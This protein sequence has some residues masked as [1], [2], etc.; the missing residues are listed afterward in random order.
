MT[1][2]STTGDSGVLKEAVTPLF[3]GKQFWLS[4][5]IPQ[6]KWFKELIENLPSDTYSFKYVE[7]SHRLGKL[8][9]LENYRA[10]PSEARPVGATNIPTRG[11]K[12]PYTLEDDQLLWDWMQPHERNPKASIRGN[13]IYQ[14]LA[15]KHP[16]HTYQSYRDRYLKRLKG[17]PRPGGMPESTDQPAPDGPSNLATRL[18]QSEPRGGSAQ[19]V[20]PTAMQANDK[21]R[22]RASEDTPGEGNVDST[23]KPSLKKRVTEVNIDLPDPFISGPQTKLAAVPHSATASNGQR[24]T[25]GAKEARERGATEGSKAPA[26]EPRQPSQPDPLFLELPFLP[27]DDEPEEEDMEQDIDAWID[28]RLLNGK[29]QHEEQIHLALRCTSMDPD[30]ADRVLAILVEG[31]PIPDDMPG[32]WTPEDDKCIEGNETRG[33]QRVM[34]KHG[35]EA[36]NNRWEYLSM[37]REAGLLDTL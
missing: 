35:T 17:H 4:H 23:N 28:E 24:P 10:G 33:I 5:N 18:V 31:K 16:R 26:K 29:A 6:R 21:K 25:P 9:N 7:D 3:Q 37:V 30:L 15:E 34:E 8:Q 1:G 27:S 11:H 32:V 20:E 2:T 22:K 13:K 19:G 14:E 12:I 36:F